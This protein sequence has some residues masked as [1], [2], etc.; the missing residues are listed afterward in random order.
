MVEIGLRLSTVIRDSLTFI[1]LFLLTQMF[2]STKWILEEPEVD[3]N[4][5]FDMIFPTVLKPPKT[6]LTSQNDINVDD[7]QIAIIRE[8]PFSSS[9]QRMGVIIRRLKGTTF[10]YYCKGSPEMILNFVRNE[11]VPE[12]FH[13]ILESYTQEGY[14]VIALAHKELKLSYAK[15]QKVQREVIEQDLT[16]LG[17]IVM[18]NRL[19]PATTPVIQDLND[20]NIRIIMVTGK[21]LVFK[22]SKSYAFNFR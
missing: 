7:F 8:F 2:E 14:R 11:T 1:L 22:M 17:L 21:N 10:E 12:D 6:H 19:K 9:S 20:A 13:D 5:K 18:E 15:V 4:N 16:L 3:D